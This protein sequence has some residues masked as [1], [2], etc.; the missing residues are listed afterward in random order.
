MK[1][2]APTITIAINIPLALWA[3]VMRPRD[4]RYRAFALFGLA[5]AVWGAG[6]TAFHLKGE[7]SA[8]LSVSF[9]GTMLAPANFLYLAL[10]LAAG[11][12]R[13]NWRHLFCYLLYAPAILMCVFMDTRFVALGARSHSW[14][15]AFYDLS[16]PSVMLVAA[17][18]TVYLAATIAVTAVAWRRGH[19]EGR[20]RQRRL[21][22]NVEAPLVVGIAAVLVF[23]CVRRGP[24][25]AVSLW[26]MAVSQYAMF[27]M[28]QQKHV[29]MQ[30]TPSRWVAYVFSALILAAATLVF[31]SL[32]GRMFQVEVSHGAIVVL[33]FSAVCI[34]FLFA[35]LQ[36]RIQELT[37]RAFF[38]ESYEYRKMIEQFETEMTRMQ[39]R[40]RRAERLS[41]VGELAASVAHEIKNPLGPIKGYVQLLE[42]ELHDQEPAQ[43]REVFAKGL[44]I[45]REE[46]E[47][48]DNKVRRLLDLAQDTRVAAEP[49]DLNEV[50]EKSLFLVGHAASFHSDIRV[51]KR[52]ARNLPRAPLCPERVQG[53][54]YNVLLNAVQALGR[55]GG[56]LSV[57]TRLE[58]DDR[59]RWLAVEIGDTGAGM[60]PDQKERIFDPLYSFKPDGTGLGMSIVKKV[61]DD[62]KGSVAVQTAPQRGTTVTLR[63]PV[64]PKAKPSARDRDARAFGDSRTVDEEPK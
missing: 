26:V 62:H 34:S 64:S 19:G 14:R 5:I 41:A 12:K 39:E 28:V 63:F 7:S 43:R 56:R 27:F 48:I 55:K 32:L 15:Q 45:I 20:L 29:R 18:F 53:A 25:P 33:T 40:L 17:Y 50:L 42:S 16:H 6:G 44:R 31:V 36:D 57:A 59:G 37:D 22:L 23:A 30:L 52:L 49:A 9:A 58:E 60:K 61:M 51:H 3:A 54:L 11:S 2:V 1:V 46:V 38:R 10:V 21:L 4:P 13:F 24:S 35:A 47:K 8:W